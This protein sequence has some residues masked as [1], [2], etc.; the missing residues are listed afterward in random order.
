MIATMRSLL[1]VVL[2]V[3]AFASLAVAAGDVLVEDWSKIPLGTKGIPPDWKGQQWGSPLFDFAVSEDDGMRVLHMK[4]K[5]EGSTISKDIKGKV[6]LN[7]TPILEWKWKVIALP[8]GGNSCM[9]TTDDQGG[10]VYVVWPRFPE[11]IRSRVMG[12]VW[13]TTQPVG[14]ICRSEKAATVTYVVIRSGAA[15]AG[16]WM[17]ER[18][19]VVADYKKIYGEE[20]D[21]PGAV[22]IAIDSNDTSSYAEAM[23]GPIVFKRQ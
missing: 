17:S 14:H 5:N 6:N 10:Q 22:A 20:P 15:D 7:E 21:G 19:N 13:D 9:K 18:R 3:L 2:C 23:I 11:A 16:K 8:K 12:Y 1:A 4:S